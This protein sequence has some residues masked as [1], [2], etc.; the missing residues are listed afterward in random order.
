[1][2]KFSDFVK[3]LATAAIPAMAATAAEPATVNGDTAT[4]AQIAG[5]L[6]TG[7]N[8]IDTIDP[9][10]AGK[11]VLGQSRYI[12]PRGDHP[13]ARTQVYVVREDFKLACSTPS[14]VNPHFRVH[15]LS[16]NP[17]VAVA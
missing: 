1:M 2:G 6:T 12:G 11:T 4:L 16:Y 7:Q 8:L 3:T 17:A 14:V 15:P 5:G 10:V 9:A 13:E